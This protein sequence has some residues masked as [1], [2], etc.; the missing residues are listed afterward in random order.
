MLELGIL[1]EIRN[2]IILELNIQRE[3]RSA[4]PRD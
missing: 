3:V 1:A 2:F 4:R